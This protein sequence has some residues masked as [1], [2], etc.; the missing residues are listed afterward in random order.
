MCI[1]E[2]S[3]LYAAPLCYPST[4]QVKGSETINV[5][6][7]GGYDRT[8]SLRVPQLITGNVSLAIT[9]ERAVEVG[10]LKRI[11]VVAQI[12]SANATK[13]R[14][15]QNAVPETLVVIIRTAAN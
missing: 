11:P 12:S 7:M 6:A 13:R 3:V 9:A 2:H 15:F 1:S 5:C 8:L 4:R 14:R 10:L